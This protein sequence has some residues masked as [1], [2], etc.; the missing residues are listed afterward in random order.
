MENT[1][2]LFFSFL[3]DLGNFQQKKIC[4]GIFK[5]TSVSLT[6]EST[7]KSFTAEAQVQCHLKWPPTPV[8]WTFQIQIK[9]AIVSFTFSFH[10]ILDEIFDMIPKFRDFKQSTNECLCPFCLVMLLRYII[11]WRKN[12]EIEVLV[13]WTWNFWWFHKVD[14]LKTHPQLRYNF[15]V[16]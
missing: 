5:S 15:H 1:T 2:K 8:N 11:A 10:K 9:Q 16:A 12:F 14:T 6:F 4:S 3:E 7:I 13:L